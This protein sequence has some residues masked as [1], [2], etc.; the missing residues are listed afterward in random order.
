MVEEVRCEECDRTF[1]DEEGLRQH[2]AAVHSENIPKEKKPLP[3][4]KIRN[5]VIFLVVAGL[6]V[7]GGYWMFNSASDNTEAC[8]NEPVTEINIGGHTNLAMH[9]HPS[10][11]IMIDGEQ[12]SIP[13][14]IGLGSGLMRP[15]HTHDGSGEM[16]VEGPCKRTFSLGEFFDVWG[17]EFSSE[18]IFD[19]C[20][21]SGKLKVTVNGEE[22]GRFREI[23]LED[24]DSIVIE[25]TSL[26]N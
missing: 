8:K 14:G 16:H 13:G 21:A 19:N 10:L 17:E 7:F 5:W 9:I 23:I 24:K 2:N 1:K 26:D 15:I 3:V 20:V 11:R 4:K 6:V 18:C 12:R 25:Y 22:S